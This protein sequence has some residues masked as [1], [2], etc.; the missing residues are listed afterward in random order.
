[1]LQQPEPQLT[2]PGVQL[3]AHPAWLLEL[4]APVVAL[5]MQP[6][7]LASP[8]ANAHPQFEE[9]ATPQHPAAFAAPEQLTPGLQELEHFPV[10]PAGHDSALHVLIEQPTLQLPGPWQQQQQPAMA[11]A[12]ALTPQLSTENSA[13]A[14]F[15]GVAAAA[16]EGTAIE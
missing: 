12:P 14:R 2:P 16:G 8:P 11:P 3:G 5:Q 13:Q 7:W 4:Q 9:P 1:V 10:P 6:C 15:V